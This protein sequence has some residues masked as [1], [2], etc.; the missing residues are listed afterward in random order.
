ME[1]NNQQENIGRLAYSLLCVFG[2]ILK[3]EKSVRRPIKLIVV[4][5]KYEF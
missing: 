3:K 5:S 2:H 1:N 4:G